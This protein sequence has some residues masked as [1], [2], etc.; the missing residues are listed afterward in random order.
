MKRSCR[1]NPFGFSAVMFIITSVTESNPARREDWSSP[2]LPLVIET[3]GRD[4]R[5]SF[6]SS[7]TQI[8]RWWKLLCTNDVTRSLRVAEFLTT[9]T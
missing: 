7:A 5:V 8:G 6:P 9:V 3:S 2:R 4:E 1:E